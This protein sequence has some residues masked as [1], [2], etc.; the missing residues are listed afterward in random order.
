M[1]NIDELPAYQ[2][3]LS[4]TTKVQNAISRLKSGNNVAKSRGNDSKKSDTATYA[5]YMGLVLYLGSSWESF[6][7]DC[8]LDIM[9]KII[10]MTEVPETFKQRLLSHFCIKLGCEDTD[11]NKAKLIGFK[12]ATWESLYNYH[13]AEKLWWK[14]DEKICKKID[15]LMKRLVLKPSRELLLNDALDTLCGDIQECKVPT[16]KKKVTMSLC[17][18]LHINLDEKSKVLLIDIHDLTWKEHL[19][20]YS[21]MKV[22]DNDG[23]RI[24]KLQGL[25]EFWNYETVT[26]SKKI[27]KDPKVFKE[28]FQKL[29]RHLLRR[30]SF[31]HRTHPLINSSS[32]D[33]KLYAPLFS[34]MSRTNST[35]VEKGDLSEFIQSVKS[36]GTSLKNFRK[37]LLQKIGSTDTTDEVTPTADGDE[38]EDGEVEDPKDD[39]TYDLMIEND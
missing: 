10:R 20:R 18:N 9:E 3:L 21:N 38:D 15:V 32:N 12:E 16:W 8:F 25:F 13:N 24:E 17:Q 7:E 36:C 29:E 6:V 31:A 27:R 34:C 14:E 26:I 30:N 39:E 37:K 11:E 4:N 35:D 1:D 33:C 5:T 28:N 2:K 23:G 19:K 22:I